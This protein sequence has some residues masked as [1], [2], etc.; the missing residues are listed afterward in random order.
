[1]EFVPHRGCS[2]IDRTVDK[3]VAKWNE[4]EDAVL[5][6]QDIARFY[7]S[8]SKYTIEET[9]ASQGEFSELL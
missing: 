7:S 2:I 4:D 3:A 6:L 5:N 9:E 1:M 8:L